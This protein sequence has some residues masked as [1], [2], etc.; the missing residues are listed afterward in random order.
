MAIGHAFQQFLEVGERLDVVE[1]SDCQ[2]RSDDGP[3]GGAA[4]G[5]GE[6][7]VL[8]AQR[9]GA[10]VAFDGVVVEFNTP[11]IE[12]ATESAPT[13][14]H[15][16]DRIGKASA[17]R[18]VG[19]L[20]LEPDFH[21]IDQRQ[22]LCLPHVLPC[23]G[24]MAPD[25]GLNRIELSD[26]PQRF[27]RNGRIGRLMQRTRELISFDIS[28]PLTCKCAGEN[29]SDRCQPNK[30]LRNGRLTPRRRVD[31]IPCCWRRS[32]CSSKFVPC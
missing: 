29:R 5:S 24:R 1:L 14:Q 23:S 19:E 20:R 25:S 18:D 2:K 6:Q 27:C 26:A 7:V 31:K 15:V 8:A 17:R 30:C 22:K 12:E 3:A 11:V 28:I 21:R 16:P 13:G 4:V 32:P 9:D 10:N